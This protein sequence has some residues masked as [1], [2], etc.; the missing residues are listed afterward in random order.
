MF[1]IKAT[2]FGETR[3]IGEAPNLDRAVKYSDQVGSLFSEGHPPQ[4]VTV[5]IH[6]NDDSIRVVTLWRN[7]Y[8]Q[9]V[10]TVGIG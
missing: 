6:N 9:Q 10:E 3:Y 2:F 1:Y 7:G 5:E 8:Y 4:D